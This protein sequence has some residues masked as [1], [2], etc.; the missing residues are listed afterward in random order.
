MSDGEQTSFP[1]NFASRYGGGLSVLMGYRHRG[2][3]RAREPAHGAFVYAKYEDE[4][5]YRCCVFYDGAEFRFLQDAASL[6]AHVHT[7]RRLTWLPMN[8]ASDM[9]VTCNGLGIPSPESPFWRR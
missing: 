5:L 6:T 8:E 7:L 2:S 3:P 1:R 4:E 9:Y